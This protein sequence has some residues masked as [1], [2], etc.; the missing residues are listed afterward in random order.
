MVN[1]N[2][3]RS[4]GFDAVILDY[5]AVL[6]HEPLPH[7]IERM[8]RVFNVTPGQ[9]PALYSHSRGDYDRGD[10]STPEYWSNVARKAGVEL[11][12]EVIERLGTWDKGMWSRVNE[13]MKD[14]LAGLRPAGFQTALLSNMHFDMIEHI[15]AQF[16]WLG[17]FDHQIFSA[18][19]GAIKPEAAI[20]HR[21]LESLDVKPSTALFVDDRED[22]VAAAR[23]LGIHA[24]RFQSAKELR[25]DLE[26]AGFSNLP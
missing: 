21:C 3:R 15:R 7:E 19:I 25:D 20:Y 14:W 26:A 9:F 8:A 5:G 17:D 16:S 4:N 10:L 22:N 13:P 2:N 12:P 6:C 1:R 18:E 24:I 11:T 23:A